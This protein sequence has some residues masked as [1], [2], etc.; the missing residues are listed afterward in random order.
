MV[1]EYLE[2]DENYEPATLPSPAE[3]LHW[4]SL[5]PASSD[6]GQAGI[7][8]TPGVSASPLGPDG[9]PIEPEPTRFLP[10]RRPGRY[11]VASVVTTIV[12]LG[13]VLVVALMTSAS[14][15]SGVGI[16]FATVSAVVVGLV[17]VVRMW[18]WAG[19]RQRG[20]PSR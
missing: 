19:R 2:R 16:F 11:I 5:H 20:I 13:V 7:A 9:K 15:P 12:L 3:L 10:R 17:V 1:S 14:G 8:G 18:K 6:G 4:E